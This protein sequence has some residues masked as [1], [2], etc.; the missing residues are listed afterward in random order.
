MDLSYTFNEDVNNYDRWRPTYSKALFDDIYDIIYSATAFNWIPEKIGY[1]K[2]Y[3]LLKE[4]GT[5][6]LFGTNHHRNHRTLSQ[7]KEK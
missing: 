2:T 4:D 3:D 1:S 7:D 5:L 6:A